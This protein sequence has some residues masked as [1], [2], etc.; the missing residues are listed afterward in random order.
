MRTQVEIQKLFYDYCESHSFSHTP[1]ELYDPINY[2][3]SLGGKRLR[4]VLLLLSTQLFD[5]SISKSL[6]AAFSIEVFHNFSLVH[7]DIMDEAPLRRGKEATH[8]KFGISAGILSGD[9]MLIYAYQFLLKYK[10]IELLEIFNQLAIDV[11]E[12]QQYDMNF[13]TQSDVSLEAYMKMIDLKTAAL[14][15]GAM[16]IG[17]LIGGATE[18]DAN[19]VY[20]F[21]RNIGIAFQL[22][23][24]IL[25]SF[26]DPRKFGKK[27]GGDIIQN[28]KTYL[29]L[30]SLEIAPK[31]KRLELEYWMQNNSVEEQIKVN[32]VTQIFKDLGIE[33]YAQREKEK[34]FRVAM[35][36]LAK[37][38]CDEKRKES[39]KSLAVA[40]ASREN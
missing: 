20:Q 2:I 3:L 28:K 31:A 40:L 39:L 35:E 32:S 33:I 5:T 9:V 8:I 4:P 15:G 29:I 10:N 12:G 19:N 1:Q 30:K 24:D 25:D 23:D 11:C 36:G 18:E 27:L 16:K 14:I 17:A 21:G 6:S 7:D 26:G 34:Y 37:V 22:Q 38:N 13:E